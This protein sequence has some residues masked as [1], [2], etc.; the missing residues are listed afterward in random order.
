V[1]NNNLHILWDA[2]LAK[3]LYL[4]GSRTMSGPLKGCTPAAGGSGY[5]SVRLPHGTAPTTNLTDGDLWSTTTG[6]NLRLNGATKSVAFLE[7]ASFTGAVAGTSFTAT[8]LVLTAA[9][10]AG[11]AG[12]RLPHG[13]APTS[14][15]NGDVWTTTAGL[16]ARIN[17]A[18]VGPYAI[19]GAGVWSTARSIAF[20]GGDVSGNT[21]T[22]DGS[23]N[24]SGVN[25]S[26]GAGKV[27]NSHLAGSVALTKLADLG[28]SARIVGRKA[29][30]GSGPPQEMTAAEALAVLGVALPPVAVGRVTGGGSVNGNSVG[31]SGASHTATGKYT[32][33]LS[34]APA[35][36]AVVVTPV[37]TTGA[38]IFAY[39]AST[40]GGS[41]DLE[42]KNAND[43][44]VDPVDFSILVF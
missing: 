41:V 28:G 30:A 34:G 33:S 36:G 2:E 23:A 15:A 8:G 3:A 25:L 22:F 43:A 6:L 11:G 18:T 29:G 20:S 37:S 32:V 17:G 21:G 9:S 31:V 7:G 10:A 16:Y 14:P 44:F 27:T 35:L 42:F 5:A 38:E 4:D 13:A 40:P 24:V 26:I 12:L 39:A 19:A 1:E